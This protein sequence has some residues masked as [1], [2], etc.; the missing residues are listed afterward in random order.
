[1][2]SPK[3]SSLF[4]GF[5]IPQPV[6]SPPPA[7]AAPALPPAPSAVTQGFDDFLMEILSFLISSRFK[8]S[9]KPAV[10]SQGKACH[11]AQRQVAGDKGDEERAEQND[12]EDHFVGV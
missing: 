7:P 2:K 12:G 11:I 1:L 8:S 10:S 5:F 3:D 9:K 4:L 6:L